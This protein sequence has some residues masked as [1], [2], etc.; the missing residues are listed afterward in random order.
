M[1]VFASK[2]MVSLGNRESKF[3]FSINLQGSSNAFSLPSKIN[4]LSHNWIA[5]SISWLVNNITLLVLWAIVFKSFKIW[6]LWY[7]SKWVVGSSNKIISV[8]WIKALAISTRCNCP[9]LSW[10]HF[11]SK[12]GSNSKRSILLFLK[13]ISYICTHLDTNFI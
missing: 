11:L 2:E 7:K 1:P 4:I 9:S 10:K 13:K 8:F 5:S 3:L 6:T 12:K